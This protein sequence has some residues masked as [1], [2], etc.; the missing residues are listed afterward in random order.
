MVGVWLQLSL[1]LEEVDNVLELA[2]IPLCLLM[3]QTRLK[4]QR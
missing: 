4:M 3:L 2:H 1:T